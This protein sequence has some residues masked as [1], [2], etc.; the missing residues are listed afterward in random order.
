MRTT[1]EI[2]DNHRSALLSIAAQKGHRGYSKIIEDAIEHYITDQAKTI[3]IKNSV[4]AMK[5]SWKKEADEIKANIKE[6]RKN[7]KKS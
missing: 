3:G 7:W 2:S 4:L 1:I 5:G 6:L